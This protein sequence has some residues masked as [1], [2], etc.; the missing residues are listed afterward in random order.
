MFKNLILVAQLLHNIG[1]G[2][3]VTQHGTYSLLGREGTLDCLITSPQ[4][5][6]NNIF[7]SLAQQLLGLLLNFDWLVH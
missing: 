6:H 1:L 5:F 3:T 2:P 4:S 7:L